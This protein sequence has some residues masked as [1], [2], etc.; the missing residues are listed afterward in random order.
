MRKINIGK[1]ILEMSRHLKPL[2]Q[3]QKDY[4]KQLFSKS[5]YYKKN[6]EV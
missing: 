2:T 6:G 5:G 3:E 1:Y 4:V